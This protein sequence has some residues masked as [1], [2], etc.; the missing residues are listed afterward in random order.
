M[1]Q[2]EQGLL[3]SVPLFEELGA[4]SEK[5]WGRDSLNFAQVQQA[6]GQAYAATAAFNESLPY[7]KETLRIYQV[8]LPADAKE[9]AEATSFIQI[10][11]DQIAREGAERQAL[12]D[13]LKQ[14]KIPK[15]SGAGKE[16][17]RAKLASS[18]GASP[19]ASGSG[20]KAGVAIPATEAPAIKEHGQK[21]NLSVDELVNFIQGKPTSSK[22][23]SKSSSTSRKR[24]VSP[25]AT[26]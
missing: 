26:A 7:L 6:L 22:A 15:I 23:N 5:I 25:P 17:M 13:R 12:E 21:A 8:L 16:N 4:L 24:K 14:K 20:T 2:S 11:S 9:I 10:V 19:I 1:V 18:V 3:A